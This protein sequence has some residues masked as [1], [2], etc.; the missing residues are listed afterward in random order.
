MVA[1]TL[2][3]QGWLAFAGAVS[4]GV[5]EGMALALCTQRYRT[6][7]ARTLRGAAEALPALGISAFDPWALGIT[8]T[9]VVYMLLANGLSTVGTSRG[10]EL[11]R[12]SG[13]TLRR[14]ITA[15]AGLLVLAVPVS[16]VTG[17]NLAGELSSTNR[18]LIVVAIALVAIAGV[19]ALTDMSLELRKA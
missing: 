7:G 16:T 10:L 11:R 17:W 1:G 19:R 9:I 2:L 5:S 3:A 4:A 14:V 13:E 8:V 18:E 6:P 15:L 12:T